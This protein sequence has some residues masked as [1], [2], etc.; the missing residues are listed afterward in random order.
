[1]LRSYVKIAETFSETAVDMNWLIDTP[2]R[3]AI[4]LMCR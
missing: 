3:L 2:S 1:M 4:S